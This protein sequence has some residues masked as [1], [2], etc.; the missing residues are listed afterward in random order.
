[1]K[2]RSARVDDLVA[3]CALDPRTGG[4]PAR[5]G[6]VHEA[7]RDGLGWVAEADGDL[8]GYAIAG[9]WFYGHPF[10]ELLVVRESARRRGLGR[11]LVR[12]VEAHFAGA[13]LFTST[14]QSN[15]PMQR[16][17]AS[18]G[19]TPSGVILNLDPGDPE[20]VYVRLG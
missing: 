13:K 17:L 1:M 7:F 9:P 4:D 14:N 15:E 3:V 10:L 20:L 6:R 12:E 5:R 18:L 11:A 19:Y 16:L 2:L 8:L